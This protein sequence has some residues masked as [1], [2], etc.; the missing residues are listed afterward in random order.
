MRNLGRDIKKL[1]RAI[2]RKLGKIGQFK[3]N[4]SE[5]NEHKQYIQN[6]LTSSLSTSGVRVASSSFRSSLLQIL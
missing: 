6:N 5:G 2:T 1:G 4:V 3:V